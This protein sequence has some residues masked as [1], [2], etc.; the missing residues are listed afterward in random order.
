M[1]Q[2]TFGVANSLDNFIA[3]ADQSVDVAKRSGMP[4]YPGSENIVFSRTVDPGY[5]A[6]IEI[7]KS[8]PA[9]FIA[10]LKRQEG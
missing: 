1:R 10:R 4:A 5:G 8:V 3:R 2:V 9:P 6:E 7:I